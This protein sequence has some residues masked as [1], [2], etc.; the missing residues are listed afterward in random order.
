MVYPDI[1]LDPGLRQ[2]QKSGGVR[3]INGF[4]NLN[5]N[6]SELKNHNTNLAK[7]K[8]SSPKLPGSS[9]FS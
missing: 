7:S 9:S 5:L 6:I 1:N 4:P 3:L 2:A 8:S